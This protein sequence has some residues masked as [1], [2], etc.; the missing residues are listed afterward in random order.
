MIIKTSK[1]TF[2]RVPEGKQEL[3]ITDVKLVPSGKPQKVE[4]SYVHENGAT[5]KETFSFTHPVQSAILGKR[6]DV[7][8]NGDMPEGT[9][10]DTSDLPSMFAD[11]IAVCEIVHKK[12][13]DKEDPTKERTFVNIKYVE[14]YKDA[15]ETVEGELVDDDL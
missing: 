8:Y 9:E 6:C 5:F 11:K 10:I 7:L 13:A 1:G 4:F 14:E 2:K 3:T 12:V 15:I